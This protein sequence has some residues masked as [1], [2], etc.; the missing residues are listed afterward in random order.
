MD[1]ARQLM[2]TPTYPLR[3]ASHANS[4]CSR[5]LTHRVAT[6]PTSHD[7]TLISQAQR[8]NRN[9]SMKLFLNQHPRMASSRTHLIV[10]CGH[11]IWLGGPSHGS[12]EAEWL[13]ADFQRGETDTFIEHIKAG[14]T[15]LADDRAGSVLMFSG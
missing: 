4:F 14:V 13:I 3:L 9:Q 6:S 12:D 11:G 2:V 7:Q 15:C 8:P 5:C 10:V 1:P